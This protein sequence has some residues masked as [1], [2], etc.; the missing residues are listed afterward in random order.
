MTWR[1]MTQL[2]QGKFIPPNYQQILYN[3]FEY[4]KQGTTIVAAYAE[5]FYRLSRDATYPWWMNNKQ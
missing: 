2:L 5:E 4:Y 1:R 3:K